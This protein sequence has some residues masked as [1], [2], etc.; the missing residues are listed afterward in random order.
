MANVTST[1]AA[2]LPLPPLEYDVQWANMLIRVL[3]FYIQQQQN[4]G[5]IRGSQLTLSDGDPDGDFVVDTMWATDFTKMVVNELPTTANLSL[6]LNPVTVSSNDSS[7]VTIAITSPLLMEQGQ[8]WR[9]PST[10]IL[11]IVP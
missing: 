7:G 3:N 2:V 6:R 8:V 5:P 9:D 10:N 1:P 4:P 11:H